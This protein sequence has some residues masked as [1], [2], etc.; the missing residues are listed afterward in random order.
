MNRQGADPIQ[1]YFLP[2]G[3]GVFRQVPIGADTEVRPP[4][5]LFLGP[6]GRFVRMD[7]QRTGAE[8]IQ[9][10]SLPSGT[11]V[12][13]QMPSGADTEVRRPWAERVEER[14]WRVETGGRSAKQTR[15]TA[16]S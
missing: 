1:V 11:G 14:K 3:T 7:D 12:F 9:I 10:C 16:R 13:R 2:I 15:R 4:A 8:P 6:G 5:T